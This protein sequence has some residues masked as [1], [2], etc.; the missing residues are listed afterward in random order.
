MGLHG[1]PWGEGRTAGKMV[2]MHNPGPGGASMVSPV[3]RSTSA[4]L[5]AHSVM[6]GAI[7]RGL[8]QE[9]GLG[10]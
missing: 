3:T 8:W 4:L 2:T 6:S 7:I 9:I 10:L 1:R 5:G